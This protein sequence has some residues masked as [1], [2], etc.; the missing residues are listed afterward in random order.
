MRWRRIY[1]EI[2]KKRTEKWC[3]KNTNIRERKTRITNRYVR[4][5]DLRR[6]LLLKSKQ[7][8][9]FEYIWIL[10]A[11]YFPPDS[12]ELCRIFAAMHWFLNAIFFRCKERERYPI[13]PVRGKIR[14]TLRSS[15]H[16]DADTETDRHRERE[17]EGSTWHAVCWHGTRFVHVALGPVPTRGCHLSEVCVVFPRNPNTYTFTYITYSSPPVRSVLFF[18]Y[19]TLLS[20]CHMS[21]KL[22]LPCYRDLGC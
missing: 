7:C 21:F 14:R 19:H 22:Q 5:S 4:R 10:V 3:E 2:L 20:I 12:I 13:L 18:F 17:R 15:A 11:V 8:I 9:S 1:H 6:T 16:T